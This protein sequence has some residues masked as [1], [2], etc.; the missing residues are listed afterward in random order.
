MVHLRNRVYQANRNGFIF[1]VTAIDV[2]YLRSLGCEN[3]TPFNNYNAT[4]APTVDDD[5]T[6]GYNQGS[7]WVWPS[8]SGASAIYICSSMGS[9][10]GEAVWAEWTGVLVLNVRNTSRLGH[11]PLPRQIV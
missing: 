10:P 11:K 6:K 5:Y 2:T 1:N 7:L 9:S 8:G 3:V 4:R